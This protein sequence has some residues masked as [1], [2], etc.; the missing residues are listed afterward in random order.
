M[1]A[2]SKLWSIDS[3]NFSSLSLPGFSLTFLSVAGVHQVH[4]ETS[5]G[6]VGGGLVVV[7][8]LTRG[9]VSLM[10]GPVVYVL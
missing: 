9:A 7:V 8:V 5:S 6:V 3:V 10:G 1:S 2:P 4:T